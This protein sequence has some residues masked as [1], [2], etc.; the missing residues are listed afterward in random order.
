MPHRA[1]A[2]Y[3]YLNKTAVI[4]HRNNKSKANQTDI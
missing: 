4:P 3:C 2:R 1:T